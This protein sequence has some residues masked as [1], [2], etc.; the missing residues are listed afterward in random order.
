VAGAE[1]LALGGL[2]DQVVTQGGDGGRVK[3]Q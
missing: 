1:Q 2:G 3:R